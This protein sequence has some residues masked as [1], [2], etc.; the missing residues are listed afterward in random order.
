M[1]LL[2]SSVG[3]VIAVF[4]VAFGYLALFWRTFRQN[5]GNR[6]IECGAITLI[7]AFIGLATF[8]TIPGISDHPPNWVFWLWISSVILLCLSTLFFAVQ[9]LWRI[10]AR[11]KKQ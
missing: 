7:V 5:R 8:V 10:P 1:S 11:M 2:A 9:R 3:K 6:L 4:G